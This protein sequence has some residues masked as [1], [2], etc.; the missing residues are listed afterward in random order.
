M[1]VSIAAIQ[2][3][4]ELY[5]LGYLKK[6]KS[7]I[8]IGSQE[9]IVK[10]NDL[11]EFFDYAGLESGLVDAY[12]NI[13]NFPNKPRCSSKHFYKSLG[14][15]EYESIDINGEHGAIVYDLNKPFNDKTKFN[16]FDI[17]TDHGSSEHVFNTPEV[18][19]TMHNLVKPGGLIIVSQQVL[20]GN[21]YFLFDRAFF[22]GI[23][24][25]NKY[26]IIFAS[27]MLAPGTQTKNGSNH[28]FH[29]PLSEHIFNSINFAKIE[30]L[31]IYFVLQ[32]QHDEEFKI[33]YQDNLM[34]ETYNCVGFNRIYFKD[35]MS[36]SY[37]PA[38][39]LTTE[40]TPFKT[41]IKEFF[42]RLIKKIKNAK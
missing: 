20:K 23:A 40:E 16:K 13:N 1:G 27:Y 25:A 29:L 19:K 4:L 17:V 39:K 9:L 3:T 42:R 22:E 21:G 11:K 36:Y 41:L 7:I 28:Q 31:N 5:N 12:P 10:K 26:K 37:I 8:E 2:N 15:N 18:F 32:K 35:P 14:I 30:N 38:A 33:P 6:T 34:K 24:A